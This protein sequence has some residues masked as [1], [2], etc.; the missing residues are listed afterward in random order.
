MRVFFWFTAFSV[1]LFGGACAVY[2]YVHNQM[3]VEIV[4]LC[5][6]IP[7]III[8]LILSYMLAESV[9]EMFHLYVL[10]DLALVL[11]I[12]TLIGWNGLTVITS[13]DINGLLI[14]VIVLD[15]ISLFSFVGVFRILIVRYTWEKHEV[16]LSKLFIIITSMAFLGITCAFMITQAGEWTQFSPQYAS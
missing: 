13:P 11:L 7:T 10:M 16:I 6:T 9:K 8:Y 1:L 15:S 2:I 3:T 5:F 14:A 12:F 4:S